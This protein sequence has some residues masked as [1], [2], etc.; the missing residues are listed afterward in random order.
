MSLNL[1]KVGAIL[2]IVKGGQMNGKYISVSTDK[3]LDSGGKTYQDIQLSSGRI[4]PT[5]DYS[6]ERFVGYICG[7]SGSGKSYYI[8]EWV[9]EYKK[10]FKKNPVYVFSSLSEDETLDEIKPKRVILDDAF[11][12]EKIDLEMYRDSLVI[13]DDTD[14]INDKD[15]K[16]SVYAL[17]NAILNTGRHFNI[18]IWCVSH[19]PT[20]TK[21]ETKI[22]LNEAMTLTFFPANLNRQLF[23][24]L[25]N[26][27]GLDR[28][29]IRKISKMGYRWIT[30]YKHFPQAL[31]CED[32][33]SML[34]TIT[35]DD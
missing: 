3:T 14:T 29:A 9:K 7:A 25:E 15:I 11:A 27:A 4:Q 28:K 18:S 35:N 16:T 19:T 33:I 2:G 26:Y 13:A 21:A 20:G 34:N 30:I 8:K 32:R 6:K 5:M 1:E 12:K 24:L 10:K 17:M 22:I 23:Y 31:I